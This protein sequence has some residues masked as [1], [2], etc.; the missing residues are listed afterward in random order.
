MTNS[1][2]DPV[3]KDMGPKER[4]AAERAFEML[5]HYD[6]LTRAMRQEETGEAGPSF[7]AL[8][9]YA[10]DPQ[11]MLNPQQSRALAR[12]L[13]LQDALERLLAKNSIYHFPRVAAAST[14][15]VEERDGD[16]FNIKLKQS[17][18]D[19]GQVYIILTLESHIEEQPSCLMMK[20]EDGSYLKQPLPEDIDDGV[21]QM[22][23]AAD[24]DIVKALQDVKTELYLL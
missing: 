12:D 16:G 10:T 13:K 11:A 21:A 23:E 24:S 7:A 19:A 17:R 22:L 5:S 20:R 4:E 9:R 15:T 14:G 18:A 3:W 1:G 8:Y 6:G 2:S